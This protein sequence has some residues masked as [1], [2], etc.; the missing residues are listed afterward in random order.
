MRKSDF[1]DPLQFKKIN[2]SS[3]SGNDM[4]SSRLGGDKDPVMFLS[5]Q[6]R[7]TEACPSQ[8]YTLTGEEGGAESS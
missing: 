5:S 6:I 7:E 2:F 4:Q 3:H 8:G 1:K